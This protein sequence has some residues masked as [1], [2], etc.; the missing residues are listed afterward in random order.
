M[1][2]RSAKTEETAPPERARAGAPPRAIRPRHRRFGPWL[3]C[4]L[5]VTLAHVLLLYPVPRARPQPVPPPKQLPA[6]SIVKALLREPPRARPTKKVQMAKREK[7]AAEKKPKPKEPKPAES[8]PKE[9]QEIKRVSPKPPKT[10][11]QPPIRPLGQRKV[12]ARTRLSQKEY[13]DYKD[14]LVTVGRNLKGAIG[15]EIDYFDE[16]ERIAVRDWFRL[17][18]AAYAGGEYLTSMVRVVDLK[19]PTFECLETEESLLNFTRNYSS[20]FA[21]RVPEDSPFYRRLVAEMAREHSSIIGPSPIVLWFVPSREAY[22]FTCKQM[23][24]IER[25]GYKPEEVVSTTGEF[26]QTPQGSWL[27]VIKELILSDGTAVPVK[28]DFELEELEEL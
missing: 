24:N 5:P 19:R 6:L 8:K 21:I 12:K 13:D 27:L 25:A 7:T 15:L 3:A 10:E 18:I 23:R 14:A 4:V 9:P 22:Y 11:K 20:N 28:R 26:Y 1:E 16:K 2:L 17:G